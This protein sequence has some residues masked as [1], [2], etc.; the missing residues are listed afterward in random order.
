VTAP[1]RSVARLA[2]WAAAAAALGGPLSGG[3]GHRPPAP[4]ATFIE[5]ERTPRERDPTERANPA[6]PTPGTQIPSEE[7]AYHE[8]GRH[9]IREPVIIAPLPPGVALPYPIDRIFGTF[10]DCRP[11]GRQHQGLDLGGVG[12]HAGLGTPVRAMVRSE[13][14]AIRRPEDD[15]AQYGRRDTRSGTVERSGQQLPRSLWVPGYGRVYFFTRDYGSWHAG[16][17]IEL[18]A[19]DTGLAGHTIRYMHLGA[20]HP[21]VRVGDV[22]EPGQEI[23]LMGGTAVLQ[24]LPH[25]HIDIEDAAGRRVDVA[26][27]LGMEPDRRRCR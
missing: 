10:G 9:L 1:V 20:T 26:P 6:P 13:V 4:E 12:P 17:T 19:I 23:G 5:I 2:T 21:E 7:A 22:V 8:D 3:C 11:G 15:P 27:W 16:E 24:S 25:V 14:V 18:R